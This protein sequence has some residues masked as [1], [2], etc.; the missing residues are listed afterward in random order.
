MDC[1]DSPSHTDHVW[2]R[3]KSINWIIGGSHYHALLSG[4]YQENSKRGKWDPKCDCFMQVRE[5]T[6]SKTDQSIRPACFRILEATSRVVSDIHVT[7]IR[8][9]LLQ[10]R[11]Y[12]DK[13]CNKGAHATEWARSFDTEMMAWRCPSYISRSLQELSSP[14]STSIPL[15]L[16]LQLIIT[17]SYTYQTQKSRTLNLPQWPPNFV[18]HGRTLL[19]L[20]LP[21]PTTRPGWR[22][23]RATRTSA[24]KHP[25]EF[26]LKLRWTRLCKSDIYHY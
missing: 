22:P 17:S 4:K 25:M 2:S 26:K 7:N 16:H 19:Q 15:F 9:L 23:M 12:L 24:V 14:S 21:L 11:L 10:V 8:I 18:S 20:P 3:Q 6:Q 1:K 13:T 5:K